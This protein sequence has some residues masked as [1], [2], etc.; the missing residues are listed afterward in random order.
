MLRVEENEVLTRVGPGAFCV[1]RKNMKRSS[2]WL[3]G[4]TAGSPAFET[5]RRIQ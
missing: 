5:G 2:S 3:L 4:Q 1:T